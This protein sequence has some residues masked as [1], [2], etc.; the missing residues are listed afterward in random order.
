MRTPPK[1][2]LLQA[3]TSSL[4]AS[5]HRRYVAIPSLS[6]WWLWWTL[7]GVSS[8]K[9]DWVLKV[10]PQQHCIEGKRPT[11]NTLLN[12]ALFATHILLAY[13]PLGAHQDPRSSTRLLSRHVDPSLSGCLRL[14]P[15]QMQGS[16][17]PLVEFHGL[18][19][20]SPFVQP[21]ESRPF[22]MAVQLSG[23]LAVDPSSI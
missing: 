21:K 23:L 5:S 12:A 22:W 9:L 8:P 6:C 14:F 11:G 15:N 3:E 17:H 1:P 19:H 13:S 7:S 4:S 10:Q 18:V 2:V 20:V 16:A